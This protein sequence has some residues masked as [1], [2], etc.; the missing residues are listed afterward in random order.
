[1]SFRDDITE[2]LSK[3]EVSVSGFTESELDNNYNPSA[4][5]YVEKGGSYVALN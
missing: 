5:N 3:I 2:S 4:T 1:M